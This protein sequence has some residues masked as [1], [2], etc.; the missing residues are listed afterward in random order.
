VLV[1]SGTRHFLSAVISRF[2]AVCI[3]EVDGDHNHDA[4]Q[5]PQVGTE[6]VIR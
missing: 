5:Q 2:I 4:V 3:I 1:R 6:E